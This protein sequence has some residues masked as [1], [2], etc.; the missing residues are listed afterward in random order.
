MKKWL[1]LLIALPLLLASCLKSDDSKCGY[2]ESNFTATASEITNIQTYL[3][4][5]SIT[6][7]QHS[8]G[9]FYSIG[10]PGAGGVG[11]TVCSNVRVNYSGSFMNN[12]VVFD[13]NSAPAGV[14]FILGQLIVGWQKGLPLIGTGGTITLY[15][16]PSL[17]YG[18]QDRLDNNG[19]VVIPANSY[20]VFQ[21]S[22]LDV[23]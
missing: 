9:I 8:S 17:G 2:S 4:N 6:A 14:S 12:G 18:T 11:S 10:T 7:T 20:L 5:N 22:L 13:S 1:S 21:I 15:I 3:N 16:P 23:Q 19:N